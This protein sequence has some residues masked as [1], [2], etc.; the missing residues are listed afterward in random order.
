MTPTPNEQLARELRDAASCLRN[1]P[2]RCLSDGSLLVEFNSDLAKRIDRAANL[3][4]VRP[5]SA[6]VRVEPA[7]ETRF[8]TGT[9]TDANGRRII[10][11]RRKRA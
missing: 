9:I 7:P 1:I 2:R 3:L 11:E 6:A 10:V 8:A 5:G 4:A